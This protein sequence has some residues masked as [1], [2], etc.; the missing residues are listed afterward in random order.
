MPSNPAIAAVATLSWNTAGLLYGLGHNT[1]GF[2]KSG[3]SGTLLESLLLYGKP[4]IWGSKFGVPY[5][6]RLPYGQLVEDR[7]S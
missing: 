6:R 2:P 4:T 3:Y 7:V 1:R 5:F